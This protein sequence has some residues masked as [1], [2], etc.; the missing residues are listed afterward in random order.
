MKKIAVV[1]DWIDK[2]GG[3]ERLLLTLNEILEGPDF[4]TSYR[5]VKKTPWA[6]DLKINT[7]FIQN[8]P[9][10][11][12]KN[13]ILSF[14][15]YPYAFESFDFSE[16]DLVISVTSSFAKGI[17]TKPG[18]RHICILLSPTRYLWQDESKYINSIFRVLLKPYIDSIKE[19]DKIV[20][21]R[22][23]EIYSISKTVANRC[24][25]YYGI[26]SKVLYPPFDAEYWEKFNKKKS[27]LPCVKYYLIVGRLEPYK[28]IDIA[29]K[30]FND[31]G[32]NLLIIGE[33]TQKNYLK[34]IAAKNIDF[35]DEHVSDEDLS[36]YYQNAQGL[37]IPQEEDYGY[38]AIEAQTFDCPVIAYKKGGVTETVIE[39][40]TAIFF[41]DQS[42][43][44][45]IKA[46]EKHMKIN[47]TL[48]QNFQKSHLEKFSKKS[49]ITNFKKIINQ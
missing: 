29:I 10:F 5:N 44:S 43:H 41:D 15:L 1:Y 6:N 9:D 28:K 13:R 26:E 30:A 18:T 19:W 14:P 38:V 47:Y 36:I 33:G 32:I 39:D 8:L 20:A 45:I 12:K 31:L 21:N 25:K 34:S 2:W 17:I 42:S 7:S 3:V 35:I 46:I 11:I 40:E 4:Y 49:F 22:P 37:I 48:K 24:K 27:I 23:D 16:Y